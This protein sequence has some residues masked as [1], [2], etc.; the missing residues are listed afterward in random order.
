[1]DALYQS[2]VLY[3]IGWALLHSFWQIALLWMVHQLLF[4]LY[5]RTGPALRYIGAVSFLFTGFGL[6]LATGLLKYQ[7]AMANGA[8]IPG[9]A[10]MAEPASPTASWTFTWSMAMEMAEKFMPYLSTAYLL[11]LLFLFA[12]LW[13]AWLHTQHIRRNGLTPLQGSWADELH[14]LAQDMGLGKVGIYLSELVDV[15]VTLGFLKPVILLPVASLNYLTT[16]QAQAIL[17]HEIAHI[18]RRDYLVNIGVSVVETLL[19][20]N[21]FAH[22]LSASLRRDRELCCDDFVLQYSQDPANYARALMSLEQY[23]AGLS[24]AMVM[25]AT[26]NR[27]QLLD[28]VK[29]I[30]DIRTGRFEYGQRLIAFLVIAG[31]FS[32]LAWVSPNGYA[33][34]PANTGA[35]TFIR[36]SLPV[37]PPAHPFT[38]QPPSSAQA[39]GIAPPGSSV[40][41]K[42]RDREVEDLS[43]AR[44]FDKI[45]SDGES[46]AFF[47]H[48]LPPPAEEGPTFQS[49][50][51]MAEEPASPPAP[52]IAFA[53]FADAPAPPSGAGVF[54]WFGGPLLTMESPADVSTP[55]L[56]M[57]DMNEVI[58]RNMALA[59]QQG[60]KN[61]LAYQR[62]MEKHKD[63]IRNRMDVLRSV[64]VRVPEWNEDMNRDIQRALERKGLAEQK[65][66]ELENLGKILREDI[67]LEVLPQAED[68]KLKEVI[69]IQNQHLEQRTEKGRI[70]ENKTRVGSEQAPGKMTTMADFT[71]DENTM[72]PPSV[73]LFETAEAPSTRMDVHGHPTRIAG[74]QVYS[75]RSD[76]HAKGSQKGNGRTIRIVVEQDPE[77]YEIEVRKN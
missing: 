44:A 4:G 3:A 74:T 27:G 54:Q 61:I 15:P 19:F 30:L 67:R 38:Q 24:P 62:E 12:R 56:D 28:R 49:P 66:T 23:R 70:A 33:Y 34:T 35:S 76:G 69:S 29:R 39:K 8:Y 42:T 9:L 77:Q 64:S 20:F 16:D 21:P 72:A 10:S 51:S 31:L 71:H 43:M 50:L 6:F 5:R 47:N 55:L 40:Y 17:L 57:Q 73:L 48:P 60:K 32:A 68:R 26:G 46:P 1:M 52:F 7:E 11:I 45:A 14:R 75:F 22:A 36:L 37:N 2:A 65:M 41:R 13:N 59:R 25:A 18:R 58:Q 53:P 63:L